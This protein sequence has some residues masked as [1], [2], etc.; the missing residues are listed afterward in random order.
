M[1][2]ECA[3]EGEEQGCE[4]GESATRTPQHPSSPHNNPIAYDVLRSNKQSSRVKSQGVT[5]INRG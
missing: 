5:Y 2:T 3:H 1:L 4:Y